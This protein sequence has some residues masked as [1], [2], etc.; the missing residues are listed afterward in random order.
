MA[1]LKVVVLV[2]GGVDSA[3]CV[4]LARAYGAQVVGV[5][6]DIGQANRLELEVAERT[7]ERFGAEFRVAQCELR[8]GADSYTVPA[9]NLVLVSLAAH[10]AVTHGASEVHIGINRDDGGRFLD[11]AQPALDAMSLALRWAAGVKLHAPLAEKTKAEVVQLAV[12]LGVDL[13]TVTT[14]YRGTACGGCVACVAMAEAL[15]VLDMA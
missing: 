3:T 6:V 10:C 7:C 5:H 2:S 14:C 15:N 8:V 12:G 1:V 13:Q 9:R 11:C 4:A